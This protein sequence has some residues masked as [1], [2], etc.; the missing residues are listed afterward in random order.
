VGQPAKQRELIVETLLESQRHE[1]FLRIYPTK[2]SDFYDFFLQGNK[3]TAQSVYNFI[4]SDSFR[5]IE[6][7][8]ITSRDEK[9]VEPIEEE[10]D[11]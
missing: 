2:N 1:N 9:C 5:A 10:E 4:F 8:E 6:W 11:K 3:T 7:A